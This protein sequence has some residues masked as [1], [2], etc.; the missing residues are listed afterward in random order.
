M[1]YRILTPAAILVTSGSIAW[2]AGPTP[3]PPERIVA[4]LAPAI[5]PAGN[6]EGG[7]AGVQ[8]G[9]GFGEF[10]LD[11]D[12]FDTDGV[13]GG[14][15]LGYLWQNGAWVFGP[16]LQY[17]FADLAIDSA[18]S[19]GNFDEIAR[20]K[21]R[22]GRDMGRGLLYGSA[23]VAYANFDGVS[24]IT[25]IDFSDP[26]YVIGVGYD[27]QMTDT[28]TLGAEYQHHMFDDFGTPD[29]DV[30]FGTV[31]LRASYQF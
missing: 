5:A 19:T 26:G 2:A 13:I 23:G 17:D 10:S 1:F 15:H 28:W 3:T 25:D 30:D 18:G 11:T 31:H 22:V 29:N 4:Q 27:Y 8:L 16:E 24:G 12:D 7:Y 21:M 20:L 6:W 14:F 9:Y